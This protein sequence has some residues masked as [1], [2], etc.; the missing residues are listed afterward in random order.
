MGLLTST[1]PCA[2]VVRGKSGGRGLKRRKDN[3][4]V[5]FTNEKV[6]PLLFVLFDFCSLFFMLFSPIVFTNTINFYSIT[7]KLLSIHSHSPMFMNRRTCRKN[8]NS[9][10]NY[11]RI[12]RS[13][14]NKCLTPLSLLLN[15]SSTAFKSLFHFNPSNHIFSPTALHHPAGRRSSSER[16]HRFSTPLLPPPHQDFPASPHSTRPPQSSATLSSPKSIFSSTP[17]GCLVPLASKPSG[18]WCCPVK[19]QAKPTFSS[20]QWWCFYRDQVSS[21]F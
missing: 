15:H 8:G 19:D 14:F 1:F 20:S 18:R 4:A 6:R 21:T 7:S 12:F 17:P 2:A 5:V 10:K 16:Q 13:P 11:S 3:K 9:I